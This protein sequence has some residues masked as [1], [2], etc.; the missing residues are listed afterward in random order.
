MYHQKGN[1][2]SK[3][4]K[5]KNEKAFELK[6]ISTQSTIS[7][8][9]YR[10]C[11]YYPVEEQQLDAAELFDCSDDGPKL[12]SDDGCRTGIRDRLVNN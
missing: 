3:I 2:K 7:S 5:K 9:F 6:S 12:F 4:E 1:V 11:I 8:V 10:L